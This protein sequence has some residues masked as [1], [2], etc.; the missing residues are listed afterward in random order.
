MNVVKLHDFQSWDNEEFI[1]YGL[2]TGRAQALQKISLK[3]LFYGLDEHSSTSMW[4]FSGR[5]KLATIILQLAKIRGD[6]NAAVNNIRQWAFGLFY[7][8]DLIEAPKHAGLEVIDLMLVKY[9]HNILTSSDLSSST[10][11]GIQAAGNWFLNNFATDYGE[12]H[13]NLYTYDREAIQYPAVHRNAVVIKDIS[14][15]VGAFIYQSCL[16]FLQRIDTHPISTT[17]AVEGNDPSNPENLKWLLEQ[18]STDLITK[19][20]PTIKS[21]AKIR[22]HYGFTTRKKI[23]YLDCFETTFLGAV[24]ILNPSYL[25]VAATAYIIAYDTAWID[26]VRNIDITGTWYTRETDSE[27][28]VTSNERIR[29]FATRPKTDR[30]NNN[31]GSVFALSSGKYGSAFWAIDRIIKR[32]APLRNAA[33]ILLEEGNLSEKKRDMLGRFL[34]NALVYANPQFEISVFGTLKTFLLHFTNPDAKVSYLLPQ[35]LRESIDTLKTEIRSDKKR[36]VIDSL[37]L[38]TKMEFAEF[39][40][41]DVR[42]IVALRILEETNGDVLA[43]Q[44]ALNHKQYQTTLQYLKARVLRKKIFGDF[45]KTTGI[46][47]DE[48]KNGYDINID[49]L[50]ARFLSDEDITPAQRAKIMSLSNTTQGAK[51][52]DINNA[53]EDVQKGGGYCTTHSCIT[54]K[55]AVWLVNEEDT[56]EAF[57]QSLAEKVVQAEDSIPSKYSD[58]K[59]HIEI[60]AMQKTRDTVFKKKAEDFNKFFEHYYKIQKEL[61]A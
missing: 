32:S 3:E 56:V 38:P 9:H 40:F 22:E 18:Y 33:Q 41:K 25:E 6:N 50:Y 14:P 4:T 1:V 35:M 34:K 45:A 29:L 16:D 7:T 31:N 11:S 20:I 28:R 26:T 58:S 12:H 51:C 59:L 49:I 52:S 13:K 24:R 15:E 61:R 19:K 2:D 30:V 47:F 10:V 60:E 21:V 48:I 57:A 37:S 53:P 8:L 39:S 43:V 27:G 55:Q 54:C 17:R 23:D 42:D 46:I 44:R 36:K 5:P